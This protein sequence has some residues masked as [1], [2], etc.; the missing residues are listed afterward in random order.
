MN[1][2]ATPAAYEAAPAA[3][4]V[5]PTQAAVLVAEPVLAAAPA[6]AYAEPT[7]SLTAAAPVPVFTPLPTAAPAP[8]PATPF[9]LPTDALHAVAETAGLQWVGSDAGKIR[10]VQAAMDSEP[11]PVRA[12]RA[13]R[14]VAAV[15]DEPLVMIETVKDLAQVKLPFEQ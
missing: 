6:P 12:G 15:P 3:A 14:L 2:A 8:A 5:T 11:A 7:A 10:A 1:R 13:P 9:V 4:A